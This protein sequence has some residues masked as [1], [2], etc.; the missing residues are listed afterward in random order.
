MKVKRAGVMVQMVELL[1]GKHK[2]LSSNP[3]TTTKKVKIT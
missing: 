3:N 1:T 2:T